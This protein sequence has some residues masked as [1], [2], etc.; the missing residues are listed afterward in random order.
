[1]Q[2]YTQ[3]KRAAPV[4]YWVYTYVI[5]LGQYTGGIQFTIR[6][7]RFTISSATLLQFFMKKLK[8]GSSG[9]TLIFYF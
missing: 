7:K 3:G 2:T 1:M 4:P 9:K 8:S 6:D 5:L